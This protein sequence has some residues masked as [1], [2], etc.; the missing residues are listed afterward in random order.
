M[1]NFTFTFLFFSL[2]LF[3]S[4]GPTVD[5]AIKY[6]D[7]II[8]QNE[9]I[10]GKLEELIDSYD[11]FMPD[12][13]DNAYIAAKAQSQKGVDFANKLKPFGEDSTFKEGAINLFATYQSVLENEHKRI[14]ELLKLPESDY[15]EEEIAEYADLIESAN[16]KADNELNNLIMTQEKFA[17]KY[18][19]ELVMDKELEE[20]KE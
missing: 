3:V 6:S 2:A 8:E 18:Q 11:K 14:I 10:I 9:L 12:E 16:Q 1:R 17:K 5:E 13:M 15:D 19:F 4:C 7:N 20:E